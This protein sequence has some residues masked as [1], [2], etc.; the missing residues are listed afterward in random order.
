M[1]CEGSCA[2]RP[3]RIP[4]PRPGSSS[5]QSAKTTEVGGDQRGYDG[6]KKVKGR[7][8]HLVVDT[9]GLILVVVVHAANVPDDSG[10][11]LVLHR[12]WKKMKG[13][14]VLFADAA[15]KR[16]GL[17]E[18]I[19]STLGFVIETVLRPVGLK[20]F[21]VLPKRWIVERTFA[22]LGRCRR[23]SRDYEANP[24]SSEAMIYITMIFLMSQR[25]ARP[26]NSY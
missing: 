24:E 5:V 25:L 15:Y 7:K 13:I 6:A 18:W 12:L 1:R 10:A 20:G 8:R 3:A 26:E 2:R 14:R 19:R 11:C 9:L 23:H 21:E 4:L 17:P 16:N 22:W